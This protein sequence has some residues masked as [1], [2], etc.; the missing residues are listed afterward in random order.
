[1]QWVLKMA[2]HTLWQIKYQESQNEQTLFEN[3]SSLNK[4]APHERTLLLHFAVSELIEISKIVQVMLK[5][6]SF[7]PVLE[8][9]KI[10]LLYSHPSNYIKLLIEDID[11]E[12]YP[13]GEE[14]Y[15]Q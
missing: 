1:M 6:V 4:K 12:P 3:S 9:K 11:P 7:P 14:N 13:L 8:E 10:K 5:F 2:A 15:L